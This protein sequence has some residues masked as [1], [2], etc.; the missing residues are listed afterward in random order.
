MYTIKSALA[1]SHVIVVLISDVSERV[2]EKLD[3]D[4]TLTRLITREDFIVCQHREHFRSYIEGVSVR[5][6]EITSRLM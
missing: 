4:S 2:S 5:W 3:A 6:Q 1:I